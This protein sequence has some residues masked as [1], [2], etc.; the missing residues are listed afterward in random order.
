[1]KRPLNNMH[2]VTRTAVRKVITSEI[3]AP[4]APL[5]SEHAL[6]YAT[7]YQSSALTS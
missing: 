5:K 4:P 7:Y 2:L 3:M 6:I 1:M